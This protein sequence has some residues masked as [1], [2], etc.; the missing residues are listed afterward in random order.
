VFGELRADVLSFSM[1]RCV[2]MKIYV[3]TVGI[4]PQ[5]G[6]VRVACKPHLIPEV[7]AP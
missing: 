5:P 6:P 7:A 2:G 3:S 1:V 4:C